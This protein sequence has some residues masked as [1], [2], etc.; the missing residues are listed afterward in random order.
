VSIERPIEA[1]LDIDHQKG[2]P[3]FSLEQIAVRA[4]SF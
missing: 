2:S 4:L 3:L 1:A